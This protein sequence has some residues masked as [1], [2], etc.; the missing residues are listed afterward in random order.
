[1]NKKKR[2]LIADD[3]PILREELRS[4]LST[5]QDFEIRGRG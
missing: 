5:H 2:I 4:L 1:M 3:S